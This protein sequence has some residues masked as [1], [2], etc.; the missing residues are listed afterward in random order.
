M[1]E[2]VLYGG[3]AVIEGVMMRGPDRMAIAVR[4]PDGE[5]GLRVERIESIVRRYP[6]L[7]WPV[8]RGV[9][10][11]VETTVLGVSALLYSANEAAPEEQNLTRGEL[12]ATTVV[13]VVGGLALF[14]AL[15]T[16]LTGAVR[17]H[18]WSPFAA[19]LF[20]GLVRLALLI[21]YLKAV[22]LIPDIER[23]FQY[24]GAEHKVINT[25]EAGEE[26]TVENARRHS[27]EHKRCGTSF[28]LYVV[29]IS[30]LVYAFLGWQALWLRVLTRLA[31]VPV[32]AG[33]A[34]EFIRFAGRSKHPLVHL[35]SRPGMWLQGLTTREPDDAQLEVSIAALQ[36]ARGF[37][38]PG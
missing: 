3:Q 26:L 18:A 30:I 29:V 20:E 35:L 2:A 11:L 16:W 33:L 9:V 24:H 32:I 15:P 7:G 37:G 31:L 4:R 5:I 38:L 12:T 21:G 13:G 19:N 22:A 36:A 25:L 17:V 34:Y 14:V 1:P 8:V 6:P 27:R 23:V 10:A 28:L